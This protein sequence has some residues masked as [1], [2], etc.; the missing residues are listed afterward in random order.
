M[1]ARISIL[2]I[3]TL[4]VSISFG[5]SDAW[6]AKIKSVKGKRVLVD[7]EG[8]S[9]GEGQIFNVIK[10]G[11]T[12]GLVKIS[13]IKN[14]QG[15]GILGKGK[16]EPGLALKPRAKKSGSS[17][18]A[19]SGG[20]KPK[21]GSF[22]GGIVGFNMASS[23]VTLPNS[24]PPNT[25]VALKGSGFSAKALFDYKVLDSIWFRG[26]GGLEQF[27][28]GGV[29][30]LGCGGGVNNAECNVEIGYIAFDL[31]GRFLFSEG[32]FRPWVGAGGALL[33]PMMKESTAITKKSITNTNI[34]AVGGGFDFFLSGSTYIPVQVEYDLYPKSDTVTANAIA[35]RVGW[36]TPW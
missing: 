22:W 33:F 15:L 17:K 26:M 12:V 21:G 28:V 8:D 30:N 29:N 2:F 13:K 24:V 23:D 32:T 3:A 25:T 5:T 7:L 19:A 16:A 35:I 34:F 6:A 18:S 27:V 31:W 11:K 4:L 10:D 20:A 36:A 1:A 9:V 14:N